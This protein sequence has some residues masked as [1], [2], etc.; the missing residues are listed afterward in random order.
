[1]LPIV[2]E[3]VHTVTG[4]DGAPVRLSEAEAT[5]QAQEF[6]DRP[7]TI[8]LVRQY[9]AEQVGDDRPVVLPWEVAVGDRPQSKVCI[10]L[11]IWSVL[12][13]KESFPC[14]HLDEAKQQ[15]NPDS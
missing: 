2:E 10:G 7:G 4:R 5:Q 11:N 13:D 8:A 12:D 1:M 15:N 6:L 3:L 9:L 14:R